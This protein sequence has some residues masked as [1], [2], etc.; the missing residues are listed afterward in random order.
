MRVAP[1]KALAGLVRRPDLL[2][3]TTI[4]PIILGVSAKTWATFRPEGS[5]DRTQGWRGGVERL[6]GTILHEHWRIAFRR[7][8]FT[9]CRTMQRSLDGF[10]KFY[11]ERR[12]HQ[13]YRLRGRTPAELF[14]GVARVAS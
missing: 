14:T 12:P 5:G 1:V 3:A 4:D 9:S 10:M 6:Q 8:Y 11:N 13:G 2:R 7:Q